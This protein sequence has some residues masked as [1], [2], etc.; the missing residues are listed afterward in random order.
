VQVDAVE[1]YLESIVSSELS[2]RAKPQPFAV[3]VIQTNTTRCL[4]GKDY[5]YVDAGGKRMTNWVTPSGVLVRVFAAQPLPIILPFFTLNLLTDTGYNGNVGT[6]WFRALHGR[7][8]DGW[9]AAVF[10]NV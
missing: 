9:N 6:T 7:T 2:T 1:S 5:V 4:D 3:V 8:C 10:E